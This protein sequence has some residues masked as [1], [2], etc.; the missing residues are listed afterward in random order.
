MTTYTLNGAFL[1]IEE[2]TGDV[3]GY[4]RT[5]L[6]LVITLPDDVTEFTI[7]DHRIPMTFG[8]QHT[9]YSFDVGS[10]STEI[11][12]QDV[13]DDL[14]SSLDDAAVQLMTW[15]ETL[16]SGATV[17][18]ETIVLRFYYEGEVS[19]STNGLA[20]YQYL[21][22]ISG[23]ALPNLSQLSQAQA[24]KDGITGFSEAP[25]LPYDTA[26][27]IS[28]LNP[29]VSEDDDIR[30]TDAA[31]RIRA[32][33]GDDTVNAGA[34]ADEVFGQQGN[35]TIWGGGGRDVLFGGAGDDVLTGG[36]GFDRFIFRDGSGDDVITD[37]DAL[38]GREKINLDLLGAVR[39]YDDLVAQHLSEVT[40]A[41]G[42]VDTVID[43]GAGTTI[44]LTGVRMADLGA[45]D[46]LF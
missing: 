14:H 37:F 1:L 38:D 21:F 18:R 40:R 10:Y 22:Y 11:F 34:G 19:F 12:G 33:L 2:F 45:D 16:P 44:T 23:D 4:S 26:L 3:K 35:D 29:L 24:F 36:A 5:P 17:Q 20:E 28:L 43:D 39:N 13:E 25:G 6:P 15:T 42:N 7:T 8:T 27:P 9:H 41:D 46:F 30:G 32:G 31:D